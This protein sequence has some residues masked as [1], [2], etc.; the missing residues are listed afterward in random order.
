MNRNYRQEELHTWLLFRDL[1]EVRKIS[2]TWM[3]EYNEERNH[4][5]LGGLKTAE[6]LRQ[7]QNLLFRCLLDVKSYAG[8]WR[9]ITGCSGLTA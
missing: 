1:D 7:V 3:L 8:R 6:V 9:A 5:S 2:R 4:S